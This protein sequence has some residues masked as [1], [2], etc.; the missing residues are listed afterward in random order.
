M[1]LRPFDLQAP[2]KPLIPHFTPLRDTAESRREFAKQ[3][4]DRKQRIAAETDAAR[5][6]W[7]KTRRELAH[8][9]VALAV[10]DLHQPEQGED[11]A[12]CA[13]CVVSDGYEATMQAPWPCN[14]YNAVHR[15]RLK[16]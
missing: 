3:E 13:E 12:A 1:D 15:E 5:G 6:D 16:A 10:L 14:T 4:A 7:Q 2:L 9:R 8:N 11:G